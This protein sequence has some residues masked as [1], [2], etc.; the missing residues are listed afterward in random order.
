MGGVLM[1]NVL[2]L[3][4]DASARHLGFQTVSTSFHHLTYIYDW[5]T[6]MSSLPISSSSLFLYLVFSHYTFELFLL[7]LF[8]ASEH[9][10]NGQ[11]L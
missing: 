2:I 4:I 11:L 10:L 9:N 7:H 3:P 6:S 8:V 1:I 5:N